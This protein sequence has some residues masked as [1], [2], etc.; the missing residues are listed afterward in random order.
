MTAAPWLATA[1]G[2]VGTHEAPGSTDNP[3]II[4]WNKA[5][6]AAFPDLA[7]YSREYIHDSIPWCGD[8]VAYCLAVNGIKPVTKSDGA[9][10]GYLWALDWL[11][12]GI[13]CRP[14]FGA[15]M[16]FDGHVAFYVGETS[17]YYKV[18]GGNQ[19]D[20][21]T[22]TSINKNQFRGARWPKTFPMELPLLPIPAPAPTPPPTQPEW[23]PPPEVQHFPPAEPEPPVVPQ[24]EP[25]TLTKAIGAVISAGGASAL[26]FINSPYALAALVMLLVFGF[27]IAREYIRKQK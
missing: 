24:A 21:V 6:A 5:I 17:L 14:Q 8:F 18:C 25:W 15:V 16:V 3:I 2:L 26:A 19:S 11:H 23:T 9:S 1:T 10:Y 20:A 13:A 12:F 27:F 22:I 4:S 7:A